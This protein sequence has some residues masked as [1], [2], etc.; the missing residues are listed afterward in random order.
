M[1]YTFFLVAFFIATFAQAQ[2]GVNTLPTNGT[3]PIVIG[4]GTVMTRCQT[5]PQFAGGPD[6]LNQFVRKHLKSVAP[7]APGQENSTVHVLFVNEMDGSVT[8]LTPFNL[9]EAGVVQK[10]IGFMSPAPRWTP[11]YEDGK[12]VRVYCD[13]YLPACG[14]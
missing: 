6:A 5:P 7:C 9:A 10:L 2:T 11:G 3:S 13:M 12:P 14:I 4:E 1:R 8:G